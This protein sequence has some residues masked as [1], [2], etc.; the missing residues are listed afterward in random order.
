LI[1]YE[2]SDKIR[3]ILLHFQP[4]AEKT[5]LS[6]ITELT[7]KR[8]FIFL[9][10]IINKTFAQVY[11]PDP[12]FCFQPDT[13]IFERKY[14]VESNFLIPQ[15]SNLKLQSSKHISFNDILTADNQKYYALSNYYVARFDLNGKIDAEFSSPDTLLTFKK[16][17]DKQLL[18]KR[19]NT[20][21][22]FSGNGV[23]E[24]KIPDIIWKGALDFVNRK[25]YMIDGN[26]IVRYNQYGK[27]E[28]R[29]EHNIRRLKKIFAL[30]NGKLLAISELFESRP[31]W[32]NGFIMYQLHQD[33]SINKD[34]Q[35]V[36]LK[37][38]T[39][40]FRDFEVLELLNGN[41]C[42][43]D[44]IISDGESSLI[45]LFNERGVELS[46][47]IPNFFQQNYY[48]SKAGTNSILLF[49]NHSKVKPIIR[50]THQATL[51]TS[52]STKGIRNL[53]A[54]EPVDANNL[55]VADNE[56][57]YKLSTA[58]HRF[59]TLEI[60]EQ[61]DIEG[62]PVNVKAIASDGSSIELSISGEGV[63]K[64][65]VITWSKEGVGTIKAKF[66]DTECYSISANFYVREF[67]RLYLNDIPT[68]KTNSP[69][70]DVRLGGL[71]DTN[72]V[73]FEVSGE[74][75]LVGTMLYL[76][77]KPGK[78]CVE[79][80]K[81]NPNNSIIIRNTRCFEVEAA[82]ITG[83]EQQ[84]NTNELVRIFPNPSPNGFYIK[85]NNAYNFDKETVQLFDISGR[86][87]SF[88]FEN[89]K[90]GVYS[91]KPTTNLATGIYLL[92]YMLNGRSI[93]R[94]LIFE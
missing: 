19:G 81:T 49:L 25:V 39:F 43:E 40:Q 16:Y 26:K 63:L 68:K 65:S 69:P 66:K 87:I 23:K 33:G 84:Q 59:I 70:F 30:R 80:I 64:D 89:D 41:I 20:S 79:A 91:L 3:P 93:T 11:A 85:V 71:I 56:K 5:V 46:T 47:Q 29:F 9:Y 78:V 37:D 88:T 94:R 2:R 83:K 86:N 58:K 55:L 61:I 51:D 10:L 36:I 82:L 18:I 4:L 75:Y 27:E 62:K 60:P 31:D 21:F 74:A 32:Y 42:V 90:E 45:R 15:A 50:W 8:L 92:N 72:F 12:T 53:T 17:F 76:K 34:F 7:M 77:G 35:S 48:N 38:A 1:I 14:I 54:F 67:N 13:K 52:F 57:I 6:E 22:I 73:K 24:E 44:K 28:V